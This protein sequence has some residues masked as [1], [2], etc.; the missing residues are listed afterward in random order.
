M[1]HRS[2]KWL[3]KE[4]TH[5]SENAQVQ[6][7]KMRGKSRKCPKKNSE[8]ASESWRTADQDTL[9]V[10]GKSERNEAGSGPWVR[11]PGFG[12]LG[13]GMNE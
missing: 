3:N 13:S 7:L 12:A 5:S 11:G 9:K 10:T 1:V 4:K 6:G 2:V 8:R